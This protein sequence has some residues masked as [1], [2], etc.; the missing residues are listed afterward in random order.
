VR[1][2]LKLKTSAKHVFL[3]RD[4]IKAPNPT[5][6]LVVDGLA[7]NLRL[8]SGI[9]KKGG[10]NVRAVP[11]VRM[12]LEAVKIQKPDLILLDTRMPE[13]D[14]FEVCRCIKADEAARGIPIIFISAMVDVADKV[15]GF[16]VG[17]VDYITKPFQEEELLVR[18]HA[19][20][21][22][23][24]LRHELQTVKQLQHKEIAKSK[25]TETRL[26]K[27]KQ[28]LQ[29]TIRKM[30]QTQSDLI[31][32]EKLASVGHLAAG[33]AH[34]INNPTAFLSSNLQTAK[35]Y[36]QE[37]G[38]MVA[39]YRQLIAE[40]KTSAETIFSGHPVQSLLETIR[41][42]EDR[43]DFD[44]IMADLAD[45]FIECREGTDRIQKIV[46]NLKDFARPGEPERHLT[47][48]NQGLDS[49]I[50]VVWS[51]LKFKAELIKAYGDLPRINCH[52]QQIN[53]VFMDLL[54]NAAQAIDKQGTIIVHTFVQG[55]SIEV[56]ISDTGQGIPEQNL[57]KIF[58]PFFTTK[59]AGKGAGLGLSMAHG[60]IKKHNGEI[61]VESKVGQG[62]CFRLRLPI[63]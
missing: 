8:L 21:A 1:A 2:S 5:T 60:I 39:N 63:N 13:M 40:L 54:V 56:Q 7:E 59:A 48:I 45:I 55:D 50:H 28:T 27:S 24:R 4:I 30:K 42:T 6:I 19:H 57:S 36:L 33:I 12:A 32:R 61:M 18:V 49:A 10:F 3:R 35:G 43:T 11:S 31:Q 15:K 44:F 17:G 47:D 34:E 25:K 41:Q 38:L 14:S 58:D 23:S 53:Q 51:E 22:I 20:L 37:I 16:R 26:N 52:T 29:A 46:S 62:T 9:L